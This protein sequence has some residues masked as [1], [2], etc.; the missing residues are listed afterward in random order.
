MANSALKTFDLLRNCVAISTIRRSKVENK[1]FKTSISWSKFQSPEKI[2]QYVYET[3]DLLKNETSNLLKFDLLTQLKFKQSR[4]LQVRNL[5]DL[6]CL[7]TILV[8]NSCLL[9]C[10]PLNPYRKMEWYTVLTV[11]TLFPNWRVL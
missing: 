6:F 10:F 2:L 7:D 5:M 8:V 11:I 1:A 4:N 3:F 9:K